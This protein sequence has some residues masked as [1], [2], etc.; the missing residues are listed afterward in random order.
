MLS[1][2]D[3]TRERLA[4]HPERQ[5]RGCGHACDDQRSHHGLRHFRGEYAGQ[6]AAFGKV[7]EKRQY[8]SEKSGDIAF[9]QSRIE[10]SLEINKCLF[11][12]S[13]MDCYNRIVI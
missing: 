13:I 6:P 10:F 12:I 8:H 4:D 7:R 3:H 5:D 11:D 1:F 9:F 2:I